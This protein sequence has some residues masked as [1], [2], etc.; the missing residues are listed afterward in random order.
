MEVFLTSSENRRLSVE[1]MEQGQDGRLDIAEWQ[2]HGRKHEEEREKRGFW[3]KLRG[4]NSNFKS[5]C[6]GDAHS[7]LVWTFAASERELG[8]C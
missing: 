7:S 2:S 3:I 5:M 4:R 8:T 6:L 1:V